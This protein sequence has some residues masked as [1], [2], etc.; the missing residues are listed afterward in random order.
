MAD[1]AIPRPR[2]ATSSATRQVIVVREAYIAQT[3]RKR[4]YSGIMLGVFVALM[5]SGFMLADSRNAGG[6]WSGLHRLPDF[7]ASVMV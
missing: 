3:R 5:A 7:P 4:L 1:S 6:F 2:Q